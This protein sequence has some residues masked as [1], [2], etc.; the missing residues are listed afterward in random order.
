MKKNFKSFAIIWA[1]GLVIFNLVAF[2]VPSDTKFTPNFWSGY[3]F[4]T[5]AFILELGVGFFSVKE[6]NLS[7]VFLN[8]PTV[9][10]GFMTLIGIIIVGAITMLVPGIPEWL[11]GILCFIVLAIG[12]AAILLSNVAAETVAAIDDKIKT[13]TFFIKA[14]TIDVD[15][16]ISQSPTA[17]IRAEVQKVY[18][19]VRYS[20]PMSSDALASSESQITLKFNQLSDAV[21]R[22]DIASVKILANDM[23]ILVKDRNN[24]CKLLK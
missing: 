11:G 3:A 8:I 18:E 20:D 10:F 1:L 6:E 14:L 9:N 21:L 5:I 12:V 17:E 22:N 15:T 23:L 7:K 13:K 2:V 16:L 4:I 24:K 19:A